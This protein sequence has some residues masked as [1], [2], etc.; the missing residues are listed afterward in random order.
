[1]P[2]APSALHNS[3]A[4]LPRAR[5]PHTQGDRNADQKMS[6]EL[7]EQMTKAGYVAEV[8]GPLAWEWATGTSSYTIEFH[9]PSHVK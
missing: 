6:V 4:D 9:A 3:G 7:P 2:L 1:M 8:D 5:L